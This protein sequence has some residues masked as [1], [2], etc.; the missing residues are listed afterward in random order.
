MPFPIEIC[1][2]EETQTRLGVKFPASFVTAMS[3]MNGGS[4]KN[5]G[6]HWFLFPFFDRSSKKR[7][8]RTA[9]NIQ[10]ETEN[11]RQGWFG[12]PPEAV[13]IGENGCGDLLILMPMEEAPDTLQHGV[14][15]WDHETGEIEILV[16]DFADMQK[17]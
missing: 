6:G 12:F 17:S 7:I 3:E 9:S 4:V 11:A 2:I 14:F 8:I 1:W 13:V 16:D 5:S 10:R 15:W